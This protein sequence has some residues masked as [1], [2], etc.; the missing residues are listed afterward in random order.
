MA[1]CYMEVEGLNNF[2]K[3]NLNTQ[4]IVQGILMKVINVLDKTHGVIEST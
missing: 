1:P 2:P 4:F 3:V